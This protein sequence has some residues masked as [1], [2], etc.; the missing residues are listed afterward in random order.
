M[1]KTT[2]IVMLLILVT[3]LFLVS[4]GSSENDTDL[5]TK[6]P[7]DTTVRNNCGQCG[8]DSPVG[9]WESANGRTLILSESGSFNAI[10]ED[11]STLNGT[12]E[13]VGT[14]RLCLHIGEAETCFSYSQ[15]VDSMKLD[16]N[17]YIRG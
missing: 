1:K 15:N 4:C 9:G 3:G 7:A 16:G 14:H 2:A 6:A 10:Y 5:P 12:W 13:L 17:T 8:T 11:G